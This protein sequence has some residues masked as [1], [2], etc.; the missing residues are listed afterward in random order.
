M[1][2]SGQVDRKVGNARLN[3]LVTA[4]CIGVDR[5]ESLAGLLQDTASA[6]FSPHANY[7]NMTGSQ[8][9]ARANR[10]GNAGC[11]GSAAWP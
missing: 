6:A 1:T 3:R 9:T 5:R 4:A 2:L 8:I 7:C 11:R 10:A